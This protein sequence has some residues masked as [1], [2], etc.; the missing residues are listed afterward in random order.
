V[1]IKQTIYY[2]VGEMHRLLMAN[3][4]KG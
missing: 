2:G 3:K 4:T 1:F